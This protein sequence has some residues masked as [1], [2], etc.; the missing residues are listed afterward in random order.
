MAVGRVGPTAGLN[1]ARARRRR[2]SSS[3]AHT[4]PTTPLSTMIGPLTRSIAATTTKVSRRPLVVRPI[5]TS[6]PPLL[7]PIR[8][9]RQRARTATRQ[10]RT[11]EE[12]LAVP[13]REPQTGQTGSPII[14]DAH[15]IEVDIPQDDRGVLKNTHGSR[16]L[17]GQSALVITRSAPQL[18]QPPSVLAD[19]SVHLSSVR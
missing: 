2:R 9:V 6:V 18:P 5:S 4:R 12:F 15:D 3:R 16:V 7:S 13:T 8:P 11:A 14:E 19:I 17:L 10:R 1:P